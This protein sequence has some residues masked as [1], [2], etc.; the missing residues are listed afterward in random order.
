MSA[1]ENSYDA[2]IFFPLED[3]QD[4]P[5]LEQSDFEDSD[6]EGE[7]IFFLYCAETFCCTTTFY[8]IA[9]SDPV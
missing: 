7:L 2:E 1:Y 5:T 4:E 9:L 3:M 6:Q 8:S